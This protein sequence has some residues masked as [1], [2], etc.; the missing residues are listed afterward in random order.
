MPEIQLTPEQWQVVSASRGPVK[1]RA[2]TGQNLGDIGPP[3]SDEEI[4]EFRRRVANPG[5]TFKL[6][7]VFRHLE[8]LDE[9]LKKEPGYTKERM[10]ELLHQIQEQDV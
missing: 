6:A 1:V 3:L 9:A 2:P 8:L 4:A 7:Q 5:R 10:F